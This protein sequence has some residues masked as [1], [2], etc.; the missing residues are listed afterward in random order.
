MQLRK[1]GERQREERRVGG[2]RLGQRDKFGRRERVAAEPVDDL[3]TERDRRRNVLRV[4][5]AH[6]QG[7]EP[8]D[9]LLGR[10][11]ARDRGEAEPPSGDPQPMALVQLPKAIEQRRGFLVGDEAGVDRRRGSELPEA[12]DRVVDV[13]LFEHELE[14]V[15]NTRTREV[16][17][18]AR[19][20]R[21]PCERFGVLVHAEPVA[22][23][24]PDRAED[25]R[26]IVD[27]RAVVQHADSPRLEVDAAFERVEE[28]PS[29]VAF[30]GDGHRVDREVAPEEVISQRS[31]LDARQRSRRMVGLGA[32]G[33]DVHPLV[34]AVEN[35]G[36]A[37][38][39]VRL[40]APVE[41]FGEGPGE[42]D[43]IALDRDV[44]VEARLA[45]QDVP[46]GAADEED[47]FVGLAHGGDRVEDRLQ[48]LGRG[49]GVHGRPILPGGTAGNVTLSAQ[50]RHPWARFSA[51]RS[52]SGGGW[53]TGAPDPLSRK[54]VP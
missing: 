18:M 33:R 42:R 2:V 34:G 51:L 44:D 39:R 4:A 54:A 7:V 17:E 31:V 1:V 32:R 53:A 43:R 5:P 28:L 8:R 26:R 47:P 6:L 3:R 50:G 49:E 23:L 46:N 10:H 37:E 25:P 48:V 15:A 11:A 45:E 38:F 13:A 21:A 9:E 22:V 14:L 41:G 24:V 16:A 40:H 20:D 52:R 27:E 19:L 30:Q 29:I 36:G 35:D 12:H